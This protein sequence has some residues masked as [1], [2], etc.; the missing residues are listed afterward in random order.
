MKIDIH[1]HVMMPETL[2][3]A[4]KYGPEVRTASDGS[5]TLR[6][7]DYVMTM[8]RNPR[9][10]PPASTPEAIGR[11]GASAL[12]IA[13]FRMMLLPPLPR[14]IPTASSSSQRCRCRILTLR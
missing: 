11:S 1:N 13:G 5:R 6:V 4:G 14:R 12:S 2:G 7:G 10:D 9:G 8:E 3:K